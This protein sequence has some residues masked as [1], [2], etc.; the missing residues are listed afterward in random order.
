MSQ[1]LK[2]PLRYKLSCKSSRSYVTDLVTPNIEGSRHFPLYPVS[3]ER[4]RF[5]YGVFLLNKNIQQIM[6]VLG[7]PVKNLKSLLSNLLTIHHHLASVLQKIQS[8]GLSVNSP[9]VDWHHIY[10]NTGN[11]DS[12]SIP[13]KSI[14]LSIG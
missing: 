9:L 12:L 13:S 8:E 7:I 11:G 14:T 10:S 2:I 4:L 1:Y 6:N 5:E 3:G